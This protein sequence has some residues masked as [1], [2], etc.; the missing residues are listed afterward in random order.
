[1]VLTLGL[2]GTFALGLTNTGHAVCEEMLGW[3][4]AAHHPAAPVLPARPQV[5]VVTTNPE[6]QTRAA[7]AVNPR[8]YRVVVAE[9]QERA[10]G[11]LRADADRIGVVVID[12]EI[13]GAETIAAM[14]RALAPVAKVIRLPPDHAAVSLSKPLLDAI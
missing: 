7:L 5:L 12:S 8:G 9:T 2:M 10:S 11:I 3:T 13:P 1:V 6:D 14:A 4:T